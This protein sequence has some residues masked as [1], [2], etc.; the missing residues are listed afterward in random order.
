[1]HSRDLSNRRWNDQESDESRFNAGKA[2]VSKIGPDLLARLNL[3][4]SGPSA[5]WGTTSEAAW[6]RYNRG[7]ALANKRSYEAGIQAIEA[8]E[9]AIKLDPEYALAYVGLAFA[10]TTARVNG[11]DTAVHCPKA[12]EAVEYALQLDHNTAEGHSILAMNQHSCEWNHA[13]AESSHRK[14]LDF[15]PN[16]SFVHRF[17]GIFLTALGRGDETAMP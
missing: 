5:K 10:H 17:Y 9:E 14:V 15:G 16:S 13:A 8:F 11:G 6:R 7:E 4:S 12:R 1:M 3:V 2:V